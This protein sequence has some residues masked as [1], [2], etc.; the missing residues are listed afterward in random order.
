MPYASILGLLKKPSL[1]APTPGFCLPA[2][3]IYGGPENTRII[4]PHVQNDRVEGFYL[5]DTKVPGHGPVW[6]NDRLTGATHIIPNQAA[7]YAFLF[8]HGETYVAVKELMIATLRAW[9]GNGNTPLEAPR[10]T[11]L[12]ARDFC[13]GHLPAALK[14]QL[15]AVLHMP[16]YAI[17]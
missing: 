1:K 10:E 17:Q 8:P 6:N 14:R 13:D 9:L 12:M 3:R 5:Y 7:L 11:V 4:V 2:F 16:T 15:D